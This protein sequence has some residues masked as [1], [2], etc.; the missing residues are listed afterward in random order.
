[1]QSSD[2]VRCPKFAERRIGRDSEEVRNGKERKG[3][4]GRDE[5]KVK[6]KRKDRERKG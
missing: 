5:I 1:L 4:K 2:R 3:E 6:E